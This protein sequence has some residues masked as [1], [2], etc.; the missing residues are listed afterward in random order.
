MKD[1][2]LCH[3]RRINPDKITANTSVTDL[4]EN[5]FLAY[6]AARLKEVCLLLKDKA[7]KEDVT[8]GL[9]LAGALTPAGL[10]GSC[11]VPLIENGFVDWIVSTGANLYHDIHYSLDFHLYQGTPFIDDIELR[12]EQIIRIYDIF[13]DYDTLLE[14]DKFVRKLLSEKAFQK[15]M[16]S[17]EFHNLLGKYILERET[18]LGVK[19][20]ILSTA[21][22]YGVPVYTA[23]PGDSSTSLNMALMNFMGKTGNLDPLRDV[24]E[25][26]SIVHEAKKMTDGKSCVFLLG[27]GASKNFMLQTEPFLQEIAGVAEK[28]HDYFIQLTDA[29]PDTGGLSGATPSEAVSW[30]KIDPSMLPNTVVCY[31]DTTVYL[32]LIVAYV[33]QNSSPRKHKQLYERMDSLLENLKSEIQKVENNDL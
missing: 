24:I 5:S 28:G 30:G 12:N 14:T 22:K 27:G 2:Y 16:S 3:N 26:A 31:G 6:N 23:S 21:Y 7:L 20:C 29:R 17:S 15:T 8:V 19:N 10:G 9:S 4:I 33:M 11:I 32:P 25:T 18:L 1:K 13:F